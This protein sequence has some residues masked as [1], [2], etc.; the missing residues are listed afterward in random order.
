MPRGAT[1]AP[2]PAAGWPAVV[3]GV[4]VRCGHGRSMPPARR[5][6]PGARAGHRRLAL[7]VYAPAHTLAWQYLFP[8]VAGMLVFVAFPLLYTVQIGFTN[9]SSKQPAEQPARR[10]YLLDQ[11]DRPK[12]R[13]RA[14]TLHADGA[15]FRGRLPEDARQRRRRCSPA[16]WRWPA[17][18]RSSLTLQPEGATVTLGRAAAAERG[19]RARDGAGRS[20]AA[21]RWRQA[22]ATPACASSA[23]A[24]AVEAQPRRQR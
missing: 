14:F 8:G 3:L 20:T 16:R 12:A 10:A 2:A 19:D 11:T 9:Y 13:P 6:W 7:W 18:R 23:G 5:C 15:E 1:P 24:A 4:A 22:R 17:P 21:A